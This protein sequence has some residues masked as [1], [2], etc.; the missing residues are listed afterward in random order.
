MD[1]TESEQDPAPAPA[2]EPPADPEDVYPDTDEFAREKRETL[3]LLR[4]IVQGLADPAESDRKLEAADPTLV[5]FLFRWIKKYYHRDQEGADIVRARLREV[6]NA[7]RG[8]TRKAKDGEVDP[9][10][11][12]FEGNYRYRELS[13]EQL[14]D[15]VVEKL[16]G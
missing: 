11:E 5:Y 7:N 13:A 9:I 12:W 10:V 14:V 16:E 8:L 6:T 4:G 2:P 1:P 15:I 3:V